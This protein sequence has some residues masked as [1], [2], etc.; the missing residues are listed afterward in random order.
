[1]SLNVSSISLCEGWWEMSIPQLVIKYNEKFSGC[2]A[3]ATNLIR[4]EANAV[5]FITAVDGQTL[6]KCEVSILH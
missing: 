3:I 2:V 1:M 6:N 5:F 4:L